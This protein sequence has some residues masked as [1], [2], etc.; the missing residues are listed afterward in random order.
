MILRLFAYNLIAGVLSFGGGYAMITILQHQYVTTLG[1]VSNSE[2][3]DALAVG[4]ISPGPL[5]IFVAF[6]GYRLAGIAG[7]LVSLVG[8]FLPSFAAA[9]L[10][11]TFFERY[12]E[13]AWSKNIAAYVGYV[14]AGLLAGLLVVL[15]YQNFSWPMMLIA[16]VSF[17]LLYFTKLDPLPV[18]ALA[19]LLG[20]IFKAVPG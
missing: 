12:R 9:V 1:L 5:M 11:S 7:A 19:A 14:A 20:F 13:S 6:I 2:F 16:A 15:V 4:Q 10:L 3:L 8:L 17:V 18:I